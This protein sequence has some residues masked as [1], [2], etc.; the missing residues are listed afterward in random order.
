MPRSDKLFD[1]LA[2]NRFF[3]KVDLRSGYHEIRVAA[4]DQPKTVFRSRFGHYEFTVMPSGLTNAPATFQRAINDIFRDILEQYVLVYLDDILIYIRTLEEHLRHLRDVLDCLRRHGFYAKLSKCRFAQH[5]VDFLGHYVSDQ[6]L[7][8]DDAKITAI[9]E[10]PVPTSAKQLRSV[11]GLISYYREP[12]PGDEAFHA[13]ELLQGDEALYEIARRSQQKFESDQM[14]RVARGGEAGRQPVE[15][16]SGGVGGD[17]GGGDTEEG[18]IDVDREA[19]V[20]GEQGVPGHEDVPEVYPG[21]GEWMEVFLRRAAKGPV[22]EG[23]SKRKEG[24][25]NPPAAP[26][27]KRHRQQKVTDVYGG[28]WVACHKKTFLRWLYSSGVPFN[29]FRNQAW[30]AYQQ[31]L[32]EKPGSSPRAV[33]PSHS[34]IASMQAV[35][36]HREELAEELEERDEGMLDCQAGLELEPVRTG[37]RRGMTPEEIARQVALITWDPIGVSAPPAAEA[38][39]GRRA[40]IFCPYP[41]EDDSDEEPVPESADHPALRIPREIDETHL[42]LEEDTRAHTARRAAD[43]A[44]REMMGGEELW[45]PF[46]EVASMGGTGARATS[47]APTRQESSMPPPSAPSPA[48]PSPVAPYEPTTAAEDTKEL[49]SSLPQRGLLHRGGAVRQLRLRSPSPGV[50]Q[51]EGGPSATAVEGEMAVEGGLA[52]TTIAGVVDQIAVA[53]AASLLEEMAASVLAEEAPAPGGA[54]A[55]EGQAGAAGGAAGGAARGAAGGAAA[56]DGLVAAAAGAA[57]RGSDAVEGGMLGAVEEEIGAQAEVSRGGDDERLMQQFLTEQYDPVMAGMTPGGVVETAP[58]SRDM[59]PPPPRPPVGDPSSSPTG[60]GSRSPH[61]PGRSRIRDTTAVVGDVSDTALFRRTDIDLDSTRRVTEHTARLQPGLGPRDGRMT[62]ARELAASGCEP[63]RGRDRGVPADSLEYA[64]MAA[65]RAIHE[66]TPRKRG[67]PPRPRSVPAEGGDALGE[68]SGAEGLGMPHGSRREQTVT[69]ASARVVVLRKAGAPVTIEEDDPETDVAVREEDEDYEGEEEGEEESERGSD[70]VKGKTCTTMVDSGAEMNLIKEE[71][72]VRLGMK[73]DRSDNG[74]LMGANSRSVFIGTASSVILEIGK[75]KWRSLSL[76]DRALHIPGGEACPRK[77][78]VLVVKFIDPAEEPIRAS[79][80]TLGRPKGILQSDEDNKVWYDPTVSG[81]EPADKDKGVWTGL[82]EAKYEGKDNSH[83]GTP[84]KKGKDK[85]DLPT[86]ETENAMT[87]PAIDSGTSRLPATPKVTGVCDGLWNL[88]ERVL[89]WF[90]PEGTPKTREKQRESKEGEGTS[91]VGEADGSKDGLKR[92]VAT[93]TGTLNKNQGY[94]ADAKKKLTFDGANITEFLID[95]ENLAALLKWTEEEKME[96]LGQHMSLSLGRDIMAI[97]AS[98]GSWKETRNEMM[99]KYLKAEKI[100]TKAELAAVQ[101][102]NYATYN[103]FLRAFTLVELRIPGVTD[104]IMSK[105]FLRQ[106]SE[107]DKDKILS[108]YQQTSKFEYTRDVD[109]S[110]VTDLA[111]KTVVTETLALLKEGEVIDLAGKTG[112]KVK[113]G[114]K[115]LHERVH[116]VDSKMDR[117][118]NVMLVMQAQVSRPALPPQEAVV[119]AAVANRGFGRR[120]PTNEQYKYCTMIGHFVWACPRLNHDIERQRC[121]RS[122]KG[123]ILGPMGE[124]VNWNSPGGMRRVIIL[125]NNLEIVA[126]EA[127]PIAEIVWDQPRGRGPQANF[128]L[129]GNCQDRVNI[130]TRRAGAKKKFI[131]DT[132]TEELAGTSTGQQETE[133]GEQEKVYGNPREDKPVDKATAAKK[134]FRYQIL[135][136]TSLEIDGTLSKLL[137]T[138]VSVSFQTMLQASPR[139]LKELR[140]LLTRKRVE[141]EEA[142]ERQEQDTEEAEALQGVL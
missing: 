1:R 122:L 61:T 45:G 132:V 83:K 70:V 16:A 34:E 2:G 10:W 11:L 75:V 92:V 140:Q 23:S 47:P 96:H 68:T 54:D 106:F 58:R 137:G 139:L 108:A 53:A 71:H 123:E 124:R 78:Y 93:L 46:G 119:P 94:L 89:G 114:T 51:E 48:P 86:E 56:L 103:D 104:R 57:R 5:K 105:Y 21:T 127:E 102:K 18:A 130:T 88:R 133:A 107:F 76:Q 27:G 136:L 17:G 59:P 19:R 13:D 43:R 126:V 30:K 15:G 25:T 32:L 128:I 73:I 85:N 40:S 44:E 87:P 91:A 111:E 98:C 42:D 110:I 28:E 65:T 36:T 82:D 24:G 66:Q 81:T 69:E 84:S 138:M 116:G 60:R 38:V 121:S 77:A 20:P 63:Q 3:T 64:L 95:Y 135:I 31:V 109:F 35:E 50:L 62:A 29:A 125:P 52:D 22:G 131:Q 26:A 90:D 120:D 142:P 101:R 8:M 74:V 118:E 37:T 80:G 41:R 72:A 141:V 100:A 33:L 6:G 97:V 134:K 4:V 9:A 129:E 115:S 49:A 55:V 79:G 67:V 113:R 7:H 112:D 39:F 12:I 117:M 14:E 99:R